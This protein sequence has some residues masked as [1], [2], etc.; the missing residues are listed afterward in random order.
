MKFCSE[1]GN[2]VSLQLIAHDSYPRH[3]CGSCSAVHYQNPR[4]IVAAAVFCGEKLL[5]CRRAHEPALGQWVTP[6]GYVECGE[7]LQEAATRETLE[8]AGVILDPAQMELYAIVSAADIDQ[9]RVLFRIEVPEEPAVRPG[10]ESLEAAFLSED[11]IRTIDL[12][13]PAT[14]RRATQQLF[15]QQRA[16][17]FA[18][19]LMSAGPR[20][21]NGFSVR[22]YPIVA[23]AGPPAESSNTGAES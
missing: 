6:S 1:C 8:E 9:V 5:M 4:V 7:T 11:Q 15:A 14:S 12:A 22:S 10:P 23:S 19:H 13:W 3:V 21:A 2:P 20:Y 17:R 16:R 18:I